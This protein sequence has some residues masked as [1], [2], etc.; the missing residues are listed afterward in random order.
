MTAQKKPKGG[1]RTAVE[2][3]AKGSAFL[4]IVTVWALRSVTTNDGQEEIPIGKTDVIIVLNEEKDEKRKYVEAVEVSE[5]AKIADAEK[6]VHVYKSGVDKIQEL[7]KEFQGLTTDFMTRYHPDIDQEIFYASLAMKESSGDKKMKGSAGERGY[8]QIQD[9]ALIDLNKEFGKTLTL[10]DFRGPKANELAVWAF[11]AYCNRYVPK[12]RKGDIKA[13]LNVW[14]KGPG[15]WDRGRTYY[16]RWI[17]SH[18]NEVEE[19]STS[20]Y[21]NTAYVT[22]LP[23][24]YDFRRGVSADHEGL[25]LA[26]SCG[27]RIESVGN[28]KVI[29]HGFQKNG[30]GKYIVIR[31]NKYVWLYAHLSTRYV[32]TGDKVSRGQQIG[33]VGNTGHVVGVTGCHLH[34]ECWTFSEWNKDRAGKKASPVKKQPWQ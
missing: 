31:D 10:E 27:K 23:Q 15:A 28:G 2:K 6:E 4:L 7:R 21:A 5:S 32:A 17:N 19:S 26:A 25:D 11:S 1:F 18:Y 8:F 16:V 22:P 24:G 29:D 14:N 30:W 9:S 20:T 13:C 34:L 3:I 12:K 33:L